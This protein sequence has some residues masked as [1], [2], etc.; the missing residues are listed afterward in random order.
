MFRISAFL[1]AAMLAF[2]MS[3]AVAQ[4]EPH[5]ATRLGNPATRFA[6]PLTTP[7]DLRRTLQSEALRDDVQLVARKSGFNGDMEDFLRA[8]KSAPIREISIAPN[9]LLP[10]MSTRNK[11]K[12]DVIYNVLWAGKKPF[13]AYEFSFVSGERR[14][15]VVTPKACSNFWVEEQQPPPKPELSLDCTS[16]AE[17]SGDALVQVC[18]TLKNI[19][20]L[21]EPQALVVLPFPAGAQARCASGGVDVSDTSRLS[22]KYDNLAPGKE[23]RFCANFAPQQPGKITFSAWATA[24]RAVGVTSSSETRVQAATAAGGK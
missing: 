4:T 13:D 12:A 2:S 18:C 19:G 21:A 1:I 7:D 24:Q 14:Y 23:R 20:E 5:R 22:W 16:P 9:T 10:A 15:R 8:A 17:S 6:P 11:G 3:L